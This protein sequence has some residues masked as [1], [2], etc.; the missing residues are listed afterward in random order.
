MTQRVLFVCLGNICRSPLAEG[1]MQRHVHG[2]G[3]EL[4]IDSAA[5][6]GWH[7]GNPPDPRAIVAARQQGLDISMIRARRL[8]VADFD[9]FDLILAMDR[10]VLAEAIRMQPK[11]SAAQV[12]MLTKFSSAATN[13]DIPDPYYSGKFDPVIAMI[14]GCAEGLISYLKDAQDRSA[15]DANSL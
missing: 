2:S 8:A 9:M 4:T 3:L 5:T 14:E 6:V 15:L 7:N 12:D 1:V 11:G 10:E 13:Q